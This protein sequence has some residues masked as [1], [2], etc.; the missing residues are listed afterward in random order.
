MSLWGKDFGKPDFGYPYDPT[1]GREDLPIG[2][3]GDDLRVLRGGAFRYNQDFV[4]CAGRYGGPPVN[5]DGSLGFRL[6]V[7]PF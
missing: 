5:G 2:A 3:E 7:S 6:V 1:D 4:R